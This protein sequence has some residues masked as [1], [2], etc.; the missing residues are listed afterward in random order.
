MYMYN[1]I[2][3]SKKKK[4][5]KERKGNDSKRESVNETTLPLGGA[6]WI[7]LSSDGL[8]ERPGF[9]LF[10]SKKRE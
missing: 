6:S 5:V 3:N 4:I 8:G 2:Q 10:L 1:F 7:Q 9:P